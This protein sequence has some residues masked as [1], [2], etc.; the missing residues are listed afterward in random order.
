MKINKNYLELEDSYLFSTIAKKVNQ[1]VKENPDKDLIRLG[2]G[3]VT[4]PLAPV[5]VEAIKNAADEMGK[6]ET[7]K[8]YGPEQGYAFLRE[9]IQKYYSR[10]N[11]NLEADE[12][13]I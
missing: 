8:G 1:F 9:A 2:I 10:K 13:F 7:F 6:K 11:V 4:L 3:D 5:V 12:I